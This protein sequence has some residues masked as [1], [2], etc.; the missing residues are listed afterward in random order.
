MIYLTGGGLATPN[1]DPSGMELALGSVAPA[2]GSVIYETL[3]QPA[4]TIGGISVQPLFS[5]I[6]PG[7]AAE[8]QINVNV[9][10]N[11]TPGDQVPLVINFGT[12]SNTVT[13]AVSGS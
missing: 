2:N 1:A 5:G 8:Y 12:S 11:V 13:F 10:T 9:P 3:I 7:T 6:A 4:I